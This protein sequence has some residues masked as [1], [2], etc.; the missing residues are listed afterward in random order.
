MNRKPEE[1]PCGE[2]RAGS[3]TGGAPS[4]AARSSPAGGRADREER[5][6]VVIVGSGVG[7]SLAALRLARAGV[8]SVVLERGRRWPLDP[9]GTTFPAFP[10]PDRRLVW[11]D[12]ESS[13]LPSPRSGPWARLFEAVEAALPRSTGLLDVRTEEG[14]VIVCG[15]GVGGG[16]LVYGGVLAQP[17]PAAFER[18]FPALDHEEFDRIHYPRA[19]RRLG[20]APFPRDLLDE[21][22]YRAHRLFDRA[23]RASGLP[24]ETIVSAFDFGAL[25]EELG[26]VRPAAAVVGQYHFTGC[27]SGARTSVDRTCLAEAEATG[28]AWVRPLHRVTGLAR[29]RR[30]GY[31]VLT[32]HLAEDGTVRER[33][34]FHCDR[35]LL[36]AGVHTPRLLLSARDSGA[37]PHLHPSI[38]EDWGANGD[39]VAVVRTPGLSA[40]PVQGGPSATLVHDTAGTAGVMHAPLTLPLG[41]GRMVWLGMGIPDRFGRW[42]RSADGRIGLEWDAEREAAARAQVEDVLHRVAGHLPGATVI[43]LTPSRPVVAHALGGVRLGRATDAHGRLHGHPG[44]YCLDGAL[45]PGTAG[46]V[47]PALT[48]A[49]VVEHCLD[50]VLTDF[51]G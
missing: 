21:P 50:H 49:A 2:P 31:R 14:A 8:R 47:N 39:H 42:V 26:G 22:P 38:G 48:I 25:R 35:L 44:L 4:V 5:H 3:G 28:R 46:A 33:V 19:R 32:E 34:A 41:A 11:L 43:P 36:A 16:T 27:N 20:G 51:T 24:A 12:G 10:S 17:R 9:A 29:D 37:L 18:V 45:L 6:G 15:A 23:V 13:P 30:R 40:D 1:D 7:G